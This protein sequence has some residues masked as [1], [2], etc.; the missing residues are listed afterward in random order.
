[1]SDSGIS[2]LLP[3]FSLV[4]ACTMSLHRQRGIQQQYTLL[5][6]PFEVARSGCLLSHVL[7][8]LLVNILQ[9]WRQRHLFRDR[10]AQSVCLS[11]LMIGI[12]P[13]NYDFDILERAPVES[14]KNKFCRRIDCLVC[15]LLPY[16]FC[17]PFE[18]RFTKLFLQ[19]S[20]P[21]LFNLYHHGFI[22]LRMLKYKKFTVKEKSFSFE[23]GSE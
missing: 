6:P 19:M 10:E 8:D 1:M 20:L 7:R 16:V 21:A 3:S 9:G 4:R 2:K 18:I 12:L 14:I 5:S 23:E 11:W 17:Q 15:I 13:H 22:L